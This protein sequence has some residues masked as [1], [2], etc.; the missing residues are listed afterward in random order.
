MFGELKTLPYEPMEYIGRQVQGDFS[1][2]TSATTISGWTPA[3]TSQADWSL[4]FDVGMNFIE[5]HAPVPLAHQIGV[6]ERALKF[7]FNLQ[8][9]TRCGASIG[10]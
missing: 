7:L 4:D 10:R 1:S 2:S 8:Q 9:A 6:F 5:W 3:L